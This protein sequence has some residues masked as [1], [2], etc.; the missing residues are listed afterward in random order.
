MG[1][2]SLQWRTMYCPGS[3]FE[4]FHTAGGIMR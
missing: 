4:A 3:S 1:C 2:V